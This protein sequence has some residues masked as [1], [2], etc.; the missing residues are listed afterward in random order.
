M[1]TWTVAYPT[2]HLAST[3]SIVS[4]VLVFVAFLEINI[5][6]SAQ[7]KSRHDGGR[8]DLERKAERENYTQKHNWQIAN[9]GQKQIIHDKCSMKLSN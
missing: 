5:V 7:V 4:S 2:P 9:H 8:I 6:T 1:G 3:G